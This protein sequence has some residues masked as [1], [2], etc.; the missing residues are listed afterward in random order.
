MSLANLRTDGEKTKMKELIE[1][2]LTMVMFFVFAYVWT[3]IVLQGQVIL[4]AIV[5]GAF[6]MAGANCVA[7][8][9][10]DKIKI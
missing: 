10:V 2:I 8:W 4:G 6:I 3:E 1:V 5:L 7:K 9:I